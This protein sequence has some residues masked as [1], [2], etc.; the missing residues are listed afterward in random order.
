MKLNEYFIGKPRGT[1]AKLAER[2]GISRTWLSQVISGK[3]LCSPELALAIED[4]T[5]GAVGRADLRP[6]L[7]GPHAS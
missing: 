4:L 7:W 3:K 2:L 5:S 6:D 1:K